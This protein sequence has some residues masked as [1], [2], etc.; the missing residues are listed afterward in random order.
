MILDLFARWP[1]ER[2]GSFLVGDKRS[3]IEAA[4]AAGI[5]G[6]LFEG[7]DVDAFMQSVATG[8]ARR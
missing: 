1:I 7:G 8:G 2:D 5:P 4:E 6:H 3:D